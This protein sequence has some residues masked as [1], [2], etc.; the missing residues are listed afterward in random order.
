MKPRR[1]R[2]TGRIPVAVLGATGAVGQRFV[3]LLEGHPWF[4]VTALCASDRSAGKPYR[5]AA[6]WHLDRPMPDYAKEMKVLPC[7]PGLDA[8]LAFSGLDYQCGS[9][10]ETASRLRDQRTVG[11]KPIGAAIEGCAGIVTTNFDGETVN[12]G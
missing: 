11:I 9:W 6:R 4:R 8:R 12:I 5:E 2:T 1:S 7:E 10:R 3:S